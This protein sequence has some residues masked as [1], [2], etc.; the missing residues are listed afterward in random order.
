[1]P[2]EKTRVLIIGAGQGGEALLDLFERINK[3]QIVGIVDTDPGAP[4]MKKAT[5]LGIPTFSDYKKFLVPGKVDEVINVTGSETLQNDLANSV[6][7]GCEVIGGHSAKLFWDI[8]ERH[9]EVEAQLSRQKD[10]L[11][12]AINALPHPFIV[13][14]AEDYTVV[15]A[16]SAASEGRG[17]SADTKCYELSHGRKSPCDG[18]RDMCPLDFVK[19]SKKMKII[20]HIHFD[21]SGNKK[22]VEVH[23]C[24]IFDSDGKIVQFIEYVFDI[25]ERKALEKKRE[26]KV[27]EMEI[28]YAATM[29]REDR[30]LELKDRVKE[31]EKKLGDNK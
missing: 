5:G 2:A 27:K 3:V 24:P 19:R 26:E 23:C 10:F 25:T 12:V 28:I 11:K 1:M 16:N 30:I 4:G 22:Y 29:E 9:R 14:D 18:A 17:L 15:M 31:L 21:E 8:I 6:P 20:E 13:V 7:E